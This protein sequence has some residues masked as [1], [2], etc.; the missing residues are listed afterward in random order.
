MF[1]LP[2]FYVIEPTNRC[3]LKCSICPNSIGY[4]LKRGYM[5]WDLFVKIINQIKNVAQ[6]IQLY[7]MGE[8]LLHT[9][10]IDMIKYIKKNT[11]AKV[12]ISTNGNLLNKKIANLLIDSG[13]D[14]IIISCDAAESQEVYSQIR[15]G[16]DLHLLNNNIISLLEINKNV[17]IELQFIEM[18][19]NKDELKLFFEKWS[20]YKCEISVSCLYN[21][22]GQMPELNN[23]SDNLS[24]VRT[25]L[26]TPCKDLWKKMCIH[27]NGDVSLCCFD[28]KNS[29]PLGSAATTALYDIWS[30]A[31]I[32]KY[33]AAH[34]E[35]N[36]NDLL[37]CQNCD[38]WAVESEYELMF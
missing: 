2:S 30:C 21:W 27:Y 36:F 17:K 37:L 29:V 24:P 33:R 12:I 3:N 31:T 18:Y 28:W 19:I 14:K 26:R 20:N 8:P 25:T 32:E 15:T 35:N 7:W 1:M 6:I 16:G 23:C 13:I 9:R 34:I 11:C 5:E 4:P 10:L 22:A 38:A